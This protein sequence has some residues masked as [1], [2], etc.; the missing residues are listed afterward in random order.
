[1][2]AT[3]KSKLSSSP[4]PEPVAAVAPSVVSSDAGVP[5]VDS[6]E[7]EAFLESEEGIMKWVDTLDK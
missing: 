3:L 5:A 6:P 2:L 4:E 1:V 7:F